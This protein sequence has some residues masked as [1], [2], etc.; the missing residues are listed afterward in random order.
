VPLG[1]PPLVYV[2][3]TPRVL[4]GDLVKTILITGNCE[5]R[6]DSL[7]SLGAVW[8]PIE[9]GWRVPVQKISEACAI[10]DEPTPGAEPW[11]WWFPWKH[12]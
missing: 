6:T 1:T 5:K 2:S 4:D 8:D 3:S 11:S 12:S 7:K 10:L 9:H